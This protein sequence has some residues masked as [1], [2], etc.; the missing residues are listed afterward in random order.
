MPSVLRRTDELNAEAREHGRGRTDRSLSLETSTINGA[1]LRWDVAQ[2]RNDATARERYEAY[3]RDRNR[4]PEALFDA[5]RIW[6]EIGAGSGAFLEAMARRYPD[7]RCIGIERSR[8]RGKTLEK[9]HR[10]LN[11]PNHFGIRGNAIPTL[12][13]GVPSASIE[14]L[15]ILYPCPWPKMGHRKQRWYLHPT[16]P[17]LLRVMK[18]GG[19]MVWASDAKFYIDEARFVLE[20]VYGLEILA[21]GPIA[22]NP[23]NELGPTPTGRSKFER[24]FLAAGLPCYEVVARVPAPRPSGDDRPLSP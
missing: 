4:V 12:I 7:V 21:H 8:D 15:F 14:K 10:R 3:W 16:M 19:V 5:G 1:R 18:P 2:W 9:R 23:W 17:H 11:L 24:T 13:H 6:L 22:P 20:D